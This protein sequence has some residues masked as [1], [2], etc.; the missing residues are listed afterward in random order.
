MQKELI[1]VVIPVYNT[2]KYISK[3]LETVCG[4]TYQNLEIILVDDGSTDNSIEIC[5]EY[6]KRDQR[7]VIHRQE[8][9]GP[10]QARNRGIQMAKGRYI[11]FIDSDDYVVNHFIATMYKLLKENGAQLAQCVIK[12]VTSY[13]IQPKQQHI[14]TETMSGVEFLRCYYNKKYSGF[15]NP[16]NKLYDRQLFDGQIFPPGRIHEDAALTYKLYY[17]AERVVYTN[18]EMY[19]YFMS[20]DSIMRKPFYLQRLD[21]IN[22]L[23]EKMEY[24]D[25]IGEESLKRRALQEYQAV[26]LK[27]YYN[28][29]RYY[30]SEKSI[31][32]ML[33]EKMKK[34]YNNVI[35][36]REVALGA[37]ILYCVGAFA[38]YFTGKLID[39]MI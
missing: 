32:T 7:I 17:R 26:L 31:L 13:D 23:E 22:A 11:A 25:E 27:L 3:C 15:A 33:S 36:A 6:Q 20:Q 34:N 4:Q 35:R 29:R 24:L 28:V 39:K 14:W 8:N 1:S 30:P 19:L 16:V 5:R 38:P 37:K 12:E 2:G 9:Q 18:E 21:W 10:A